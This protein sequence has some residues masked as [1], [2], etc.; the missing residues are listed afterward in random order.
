MLGVKFIYSSSVNESC[1]CAR[2]T[3]ALQQVIH[4]RTSK[5]NGPPK[6]G[7]VFDDTVLRW[8]RSC[9]V[10]VALTIRCLPANS[11]YSLKTFFL[12]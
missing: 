6:R 2:F 5:G 1:S 4:E 8:V 7:V 11:V 9:P 3:L 10:L 12:E